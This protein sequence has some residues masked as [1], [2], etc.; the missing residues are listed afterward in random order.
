VD[1]KSQAAPGRRKV[2]ALLAALL[3]LSAGASAS[4]ARAAGTGSD[5]G[6]D[7]NGDGFADL[8]VGVPQEDVDGLDDAG[9]VEVIYGTSHGLD[10]DAPIDVLFWNQNN[11]V[12]STIVAEPHDQFGYALAAG[13]FDGDGFDDL[14]I[15][16]PYEDVVT[17]IGEVIDAGVVHVLRG[18]RS[19][20]RASAA[21]L[22]QESLGLRGSVEAHDSFGAALAAG[23]FGLGSRDDLA[24]GVPGESIRSLAYAGAVNVFYGTSSGFTANSIHVWYQGIAGIPG[25]P[26]EDDY[27]GSV[28][29]AGD[30]GG[31]GEVEDLAV[32]VPFEDVGSETDAGAVNVIYGSDL[33][34]TFQG[35]QMWHQ[36]KSGIDGTAEAY[37]HFG[38][39]LA[40]A[41]FGKG[42]RGDLAIGVPDEDRS[43]VN[44]GVVHALY[45]SASGLSATGAQLWDQGSPGIQEAPGTGDEFG[46]AL[47]VGDFGPD[48]TA[49]LAVGVPN[50]DI[51]KFGFDTLSGGGVNIL[52]GSSSGLTTTGNE[53]WSQ[54]G[55]TFEGG[56][57]GV[58]E[59]FDQ[60]GWALGAGDFG[61]G[62]AD[63]LA[64]GVPNENK[65]HTFTSP[66]RGV[67]AVN[68]LY[69]GAVS[70]ALRVVDDQFWWQADDSLHDSAEKY[71]HFGSVFAG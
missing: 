66:T 58:S 42:D 16:V 31:P 46:W 62:A 10:G 13:D 5:V 33:G 71:D 22:T 47:A 1:G 6:A 18:S 35:A 44:S 17:S 70:T 29:E 53:F 4:S 57:E 23:D 52:L 24:V 63:D 38:W 61:R 28:L 37:D 25:V 20:L 7:F 19:G 50:E 8:A 69:G 64:I 59:N 68:V 32:G 3:L 51:E 11:L 48:G 9:A 60:F 43:F 26:E 14:A 30:L 27:F 55:E 65:E 12:V 49:D 34:L 21:V 2:V 15:G 41:N 40:A 39:A 56:I 45:G 36:D 67:G 54:D